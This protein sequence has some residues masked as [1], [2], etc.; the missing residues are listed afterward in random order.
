MMFGRRRTRRQ[1]VIS[2]LTGVGL[3]TVLAVMVGTLTTN[4]LIVGT[5]AMTALGLIGIWFFDSGPEWSWPSDIADY[6][7]IVGMIG[8]W[9]AFTES[10]LSWVIAV[11]FYW[12][13]ATL[14][15]RG[16]RA[17]QT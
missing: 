9:D 10:I 15:R 17:R 8:F 2:L 13:L 4:Q 3:V 14:V 11:I 7:A 6:L 1:L 12:G 5:L 16:R